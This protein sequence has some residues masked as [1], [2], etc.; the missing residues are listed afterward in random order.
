[1]I[2]YVFSSSMMRLSLPQKTTDGLL[3]DGPEPQPVVKALRIAPR[4]CIDVCCAIL[5][6]RV[7]ESLTHN[8]GRQ[9]AASIGRIRP[10]G[11]NAS[12]SLARKEL[13]AAGGLPI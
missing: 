6:Q 4:F 2:R 13:A 5:S 10:D 8:G 3:G 11:F 7:R 9:T 1:M 12:Q